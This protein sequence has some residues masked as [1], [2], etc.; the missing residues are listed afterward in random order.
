MTETAQVEESRL[1]KQDDSRTKLLN[2]A[3]KKGKNAT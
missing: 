3:I 1:L 2:A